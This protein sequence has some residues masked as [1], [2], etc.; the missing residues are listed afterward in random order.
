MVIDQH[1][2]VDIEEVQEKLITDLSLLQE[3]IVKGSEPYLNIFK[4]KNSEEKEMFQFKLIA[5]IRHY[6]EKNEKINISIRRIM[7][8]A[9]KKTALIRQLKLKLPD[10]AVISDFEV[11]EAYQIDGCYVHSMS[12][13]MEFAETTNSLAALEKLK[14]FRVCLGKDL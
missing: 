13:L 10:F 11:P 1:D 7:R 3:L 5:F 8:A 14:D 4:S 2:D 9:C 12:T 6:V